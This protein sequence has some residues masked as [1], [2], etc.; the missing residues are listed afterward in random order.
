MSTTIASVVE[1]FPSPASV[2]GG[3]EGLA[4]FASRLAGGGFVEHPQLLLERELAGGFAG[5]ELD[6]VA[7]GLEVDFIPGLEAELLSDGLGDGEL[8]L[9][10][11]SGHGL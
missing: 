11:D 2:L 4:L 7:G 6:E 9:G 10:I 3:F 5:D 8:E 1:V